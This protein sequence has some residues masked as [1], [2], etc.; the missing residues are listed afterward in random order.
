MYILGPLKRPLR[1]LLVTTIVAAI[2]VRVAAAAPVSEDIPIAGGRTAL[3]A[4][5]NIH[6][7]PD[8]GRFISEAAR[9]IHGVPERKTATPEMLAAQLRLAASSGGASELVPVPLTAA[10]WSDAIFARQVS[11]D[12]L[13]IA[14][15]GDRSASLVAHGLAALDDDTLDYF[16]QHP[17]LLTQIHTLAAEPFA[18][19][20]SALRIREG[21]V[22]P[23]G[24][25]DAVVLWE[26]VIGEPVIRPDRFISALFTRVDAR[27]AALYDAIG[28][29]DAPRQRFALGLWIADPAS[30]LEAM[31][32]LAAAAV[33]AGDIRVLRTQPFARHPYD[34][35]AAL[36]RIRVESS[37]RPVEPAARAFWERAFESAD[38]PADPAKLLAGA[39]RPDVMIDAAYLVALTA[40]G[41]IRVRAERL[42]AFAFGQRVFG[43]VSP[44]ELPDAFVAVRAFRRYRMLMITLERVGIQKP[45]TYAL[46]ARVAARLATPD[47][48][49]AFVAT[50]QFQG[51]L[52]VLWRMRA[53]G[54]LD[55]AAAE[56][57][58]DRLLAVPINPSS[59]YLGGILRW[60][61]EDLRSALGPAESLDGAIE[62]A[63]AGR[64]EGD[65]APKIEW[66]GKLY[67]VDLAAGERARLQR[68]REKLG[69][70]TLDVALELASAARRLTSRER[71]EPIADVSAELTAAG[72]RQ[73]PESDGLPDIDAEGFPPGVP[74]PPNPRAALRKAIA[75][76]SRNSGTNGARAAVAASEL[77]NAAEQAAA[78]ALVALAYAI[79]LG[80]PEGAALLPGNVSRR[81][82]FG[83]N[84]RDTDQRLRAAWMIPRQ[85]VSPGVPWHLDGSL[86]GLDV[87][88]A[89]TG[90]RRLS[91]DRALAA[92]T[93]TSNERETLVVTHGLMNP[94]LLTDA[95]RD[96]IA[97]AIERGRRRVAGASAA[98]MPGI[99]D[100]LSM[101][102]WR[103]RALVWTAAHDRARTEAM[104]SLRE[105][106]T[107]GKPR[108]ADLDLDPWGTS[109]MVS[110]GCL[111]TRMP[112][113]ERLP[114]FAG[115]HQIG[116]FAT[117][118]PDLNLHIARVLSHLHL[119]A[120]LAKYVVSAAMLD[121][122]DE[123]RATDADDWLSLVRAAAAV[124]Q[125]RIED[126]VAAAAADGPLVLDASR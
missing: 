123:V 102:G 114:L 3:A 23:P 28:Q 120:R 7:I 10:I 92:P 69:G 8:R 119:P 57:L 49:R 82:D 85:D 126:Y 67:R 60:F 86:L 24:G 88:L 71:T 118:V 1:C 111:C 59:Q 103:R 34:L 65:A 89:H 38:L 20:A 18:V 33:A 42:D 113:L 121:F 87:A 97:S 110:D 125:D 13:A 61:D 31:R 26:Q 4:A 74:Q 40:P 14:I 93:L 27:I 83:F 45:S 22:L 62:A 11:R 16:G 41:D 81:H 106:L 5:F 47:A 108:G 72:R 52:V 116:L 17:A 50:A 91:A 36:M 63:V 70:A 53:V 68:V 94:L 95:A 122:V 44:P 124:P 107:L 76:L 100:E 25:A 54:T 48:E 6:P 79:S 80:D 21:A 84:Q 9:L 117:F 43:R 58:V 105:L 115:R 98:D 75:E 109:A 51:A 30:R 2:F 112:A 73:F 90:L 32:A 12:E 77:V 64:D 15:L 99:V 39:P 35:A 37:G 104:F 78:Q 96:D 56:R 55:G 66:E 101:D 19:F 29:L 46:A